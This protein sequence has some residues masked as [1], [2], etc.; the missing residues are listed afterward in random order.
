M[1]AELYQ[2][3]R[4]LSTNWDKNCSPYGRPCGSCPGRSSIELCGGRWGRPGGSCP[5]DPVWTAYWLVSPSSVDQ[6]IRTP[7]CQS[8]DSYSLTLLG[9]HV[10]SR[11]RSF[12]VLYPLGTVRMACR[13]LSWLSVKLGWDGRGPLSRLRIFSQSS[14]WHS[15]M[16]RAV[17]D[18]ANFIRFDDRSSVAFAWPACELHGTS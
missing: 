8:V 13:L 2:R 9:W 11:S 6:L 4:S 14:M 7:H 1:I 12:I 10:C 16:S 5:L 15:W 3:K 18:C 17:L